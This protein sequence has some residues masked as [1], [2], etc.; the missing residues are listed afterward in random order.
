[1]VADRASGVLVDHTKVHSVNYE[2]Q[3]YQTR[4]PL[5]AGPSPQ[6]QPVI[7]QAGGS[8][9]GRRFAGAH[10]DTIVVNA[11][12]IE[13]MREYR[14]DVHRHMIAAGRSPSD[15][16]TLYLINPIL[17]ETM[18]EAEERRDRRQ[19]FAEAQI[20]QRLAQFGKITNIDFGKFDLDK[21]LPDDVTTNGHQ[22][23]LE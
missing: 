6:G 10:A 16:K 12:G 21:P 13:A 9:R 18:A 1:M 5:N 11:K 14:E 20:D 23:N 2:G 17:G 15:C 22:L 19:A 7:A 8:L 3:Y 4:G